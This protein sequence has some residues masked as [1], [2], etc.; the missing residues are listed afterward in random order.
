MSPSAKATHKTPDGLVPFVLMHFKTH[1]A[2]L[3]DN[4]ITHDANRPLPEPML[5]KIY[6]A[7]WR[8]KPT[9]DQNWLLNL[10]KIRQFKYAQLKSA[11]SCYGTVLHM[12][13][14]LQDNA[15]EA[16]VQ[17]LEQRVHELEDVNNSLLSHVRYIFCLNA[18]ALRRCSCNFRLSTFQNHI[19]DR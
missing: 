18:F 14:L 13:R 7:T 11:V 17:Q 8:H 15:L 9:M 12:H 6:V 5:S 2:P 16:K 1:D 4:V 10:R 3:D 19:N